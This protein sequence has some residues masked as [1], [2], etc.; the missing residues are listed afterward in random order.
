MCALTLKPPSS[1]NSVRIGIA[2]KMDDRPSESD[3][4]EKFCVNKMPPSWLSPGNL[5]RTPARETLRVSRRARRAVRDLLQRHALPRDRQGDRA[6]ART[7]R[8]RG[9]L[10]RGA[11]LLR[12]DALQLGLR[13]RGSRARA[14][15]R[16]RLRGRR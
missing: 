2:A 8:L 9:R 12:A 7:P 11:D 14:P 10:S 6:A 3:T 5:P 15:L 1:T 16:A 4:G 13:A